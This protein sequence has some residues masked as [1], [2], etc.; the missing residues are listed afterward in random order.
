[1]P[2][3]RDVASEPLVGG[4]G[5]DPR[6]DDSPYA[7]PPCAVYF[8]DEHH[9]F[10]GPLY[11]PLQFLPESWK[12]TISSGTH[13]N[14]IGQVY[15]H[16]IPYEAGH[17]II[18]W[19]VSGTYRSLES[20]S[21]E[22]GFT[23]ALHV[24]IAA[25]HLQFPVLRDAVEMEIMNW[26]DELSLPSI[27]DMMDAVKLPLATFPRIA[28]YIEN[29]M[30]FFAADAFNTD[31]NKVPKELESPKTLG[32]VLLKNMVQSKIAELS[33]KSKIAELSAQSSIPP[34]TVSEELA[35]L[36]SV[37]IVTDEF[38]GSAVQTNPGLSLE[39]ALGQ[40]R[41]YPG[42]QTGQSASD[43]TEEEILREEAEIKTLLERKASKKGKFIYRDELRLRLLQSWAA[44]RAF[45][46]RIRDIKEHA[47]RQRV[48]NERLWFMQNNRT[49]PVESEDVKTMRY[50]AKLGRILAQGT[51]LGRLFPE[52]GQI[53]DLLEKKWA[54]RG[55]LGFFSTPKDTP[56]APELAA[57][58]KGLVW[59]AVKTSH[60][61]ASSSKQIPDPAETAMPQGDSENNSCTGWEDDFLAPEGG[62]GSPF[63]EW[64][65]PVTP[66]TSE[67]CL[68]CSIP[69]TPDFDLGIW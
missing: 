11:V 31:P 42:K 24:C 29:R 63:S 4:L 3:T 38:P 61:E 46:K 36:E 30:L 9:Q 53:L 26:G 15:L 45:T 48:W 34:E 65:R 51:P 64:D 12:S 18:H 69:G 50:E 8:R 52:D 39:G 16:G 14:S 47:Q 44:K 27:I 28:Q 35:P 13:D 17:A 21:H 62:D 56:P 49:L 68:R 5:I 33:L 25:N 59:G 40:P 32:Q 19:L 37:K 10:R 41:E 55:S 1:M 57:D 22:Y 66:G 23:T 20:W 67:E 54:K 60:S 7:S 2:S 43:A 58:R 6:P